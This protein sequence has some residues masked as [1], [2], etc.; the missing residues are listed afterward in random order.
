MSKIDGIA[1]DIYQ[2]EKSHISKIKENS[3][4]V[5]AAGLVIIMALLGLGALQLRE[6]SLKSVINMIIETVPFYM[7]ASI[8]SMNYYKKGVYTAKNANT[9]ISVVD[10]YSTMVHKLTG[11]QL[12]W[13]NEFCVY[14]NARVLRRLQ[15]GILIRFAI[16]YDRFEYGS[17]SEPPLK[18]VSYDE[19]SEKYGKEFA[20]TVKDAKEVGIKGLHANI[21]LGSFGDM[22]TTNLGPTEAELF[23][24]RNTMY[25]ITNAISVVVMALIGIKDVLSW[26]WFGAVLVVFKVGYIFCRAY[27]KY[28]DG[29]EDISNKVVNHISRKID[30]FKEFFYWYD[31]KFKESDTN[32]LTKSDDIS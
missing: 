31:E 3:F 9:F 22:D 20:D 7:T 26:G 4:D 27:M 18:C 12:D 6:M 11:H 19:L 13:L 14:Y 23:K 5:V 17:E 15:E 25:M 2:S 24:S 1:T 8:L 10:S 30:I 28:F 29:Y 21:L 16:S 32:V